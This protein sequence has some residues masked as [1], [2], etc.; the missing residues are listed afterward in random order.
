VQWTA[1]L[2]R[3][4]PRCSRSRPTSPKAKAT[5]LGIPSKQESHGIQC[6]DHD[7]GGFPERSTQPMVGS[8]NRRATCHRSFD[9]SARGSNSN[10]KPRSAEKRCDQRHLLT[11]GRIAP[12]CYTKQAFASTIPL[13]QC[14][15]KA[16][17]SETR[18]ICGDCR[19]NLDS[20]RSCRGHESRGA[21]KTRD[22]SGV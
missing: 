13:R 10:S 19:Q 7:A 14:L 6:V 18:R 4:V 15:A 9:G 22:D 17:L 5:G 1:P 8:R 12:A 20:G 3:E 16:D 21:L 11:S 2:S